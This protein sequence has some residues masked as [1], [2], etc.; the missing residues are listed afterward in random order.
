MVLNRRVGPNHL[1]A[2]ASVHANR[3]QIVLLC[4]MDYPMD[5]ASTDV[6]SRMHLVSK[7]ICWDACHEAHLFHSLPGNQQFL[8]NGLVE[9]DFD[10]YTFMDVVLVRNYPKPVLCLDERSVTLKHAQP[11]WSKMCEVVELC[12]GFGG[13]TPG[14]EVLGFVPTLAVDFNEKMLQL[15]RKHGDCPTLVGD[16]TC[17]DTVK[18]IWSC[19]Q[20][21]AVITAGY[22]CQPFSQ[23][24]D[25]K[26]EFD[27][28][29]LCLR[30]VLATAFYT[31]AQ[32]IILECVIPAASNTWVKQEIQKFVDS[33]GFI[34]TQT[35]LHLHQIWPSRRS[36]AWWL[37]ITPWIGKVP[38]LPWPQQ[39]S[40]SKV[41]QV[42][43]RILAWDVVDERNLLLQTVE[44]T[45]FGVDDETF[46]RFLLN[47]E[48]VSP[49][50]LHSW[51]LQLL[52]CECGCRSFGLSSHRIAE[53]GL[54]GLL[55]RSTSDA[56][57][58]E[59][60][61]IHPNECLALQGFDPVI[62]FGNQ[63]RL[64]LAAVGQMASPFQS[65]WIFSC[66]ADRL[67]QL[68]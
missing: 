44:K 14:Y 38:I 52:P 5:F 41:A 17:I 40:V 10:L 50:A 25:R 30:G 24:G 46:S 65:L 64:T 48:G 59:L 12:S 16:V 6:G 7:K 33:T 53:K 39:P 2:G 26:G 49:C 1:P 37:L 18:Q 9:G 20:G 62:D 45:A 27:V 43:P 56:F 32:A 19:T 29:A 36:R 3:G 57:Y 8:L 11:S 31:R 63:T 15:Y 47:H 61:H 13:M 51:G 67:A 4:A 42:I 55:V 23:L 28:R 58:H 68:S 21:V 66:L 54:F 22:A 60:R 34:L 35:E